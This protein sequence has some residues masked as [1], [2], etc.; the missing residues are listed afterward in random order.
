MR[1]PRKTGAFRRAPATSTIRWRLLRD[2]DR[3][4]TA[5]WGRRT[6]SAVS[7]ADC[8]RCVHGAG[9]L[10]ALV[11]GQPPVPTPRCTDATVRFRSPSEARR[12]RRFIRRPGSGVTAA[13]GGSLWTRIGRAMIFLSQRTQLLPQLGD[14]SRQLGIPPGAADSAGSA[15]H[16]PE[17][18][19][20]DG[21]D[22][23]DRDERGEPGG[24]QRVPSRRCARSALS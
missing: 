1:L 15:P 2:R 7:L 12:S 22:H 23:S 20:L 4:Q 18:E 24:H 10:G 8:A 5:P 17:T 16:R 3:R 14:L 21:D 19:E 11:Q 13:R 6:V 9:P